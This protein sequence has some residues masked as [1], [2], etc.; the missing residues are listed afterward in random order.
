M[1]WIDSIKEINKARTNNRLVIF[2]GSGVSNNS[3]VPTWKGLIETIAKKIN[4]NEKCSGCDSIETSCPKEDCSK[5][6]DF[7]ATEFLRIP[8]YYYQSASTDEYFQTISNT[9][10]CDKESN[11]VDEMILDIAPHHIIT[12]N[13]DTLLENTTSINTA[14]YK[15]IYEDKDLLSN[16]SDGYIIKMHGDIDHPKTI[17]LK[18]SD[19]IDYEQTHPLISTYIKSLLVN[20]T[21]LFVGYSLNDNNLNLIIGWINYFCKQYDVSERPYSFLI[22]NA[23]PSDF[24]LS[25]LEKNNIFVIGLDTLPSDLQSK[26]NVPESL[27]HPSGRNLYTYLECITNNTISSQY[28]ELKDILNER[29]EVLKPYCKIAHEDLL[30][31]YSFGTHQILNTVLILYD[32]P[33]YYKLTALLTEDNPLILNT[34]QRAG[35]TSVQ[36]DSDETYSYDI[37]CVNRPSLVQLYLD[38]DYTSIENQI[39]YLS[40]AEKIYYYNLLGMAFNKDELIH[41]DLKSI[42]KNDYI[43]VLLHKTRARL[44]SLTLTDRQAA[45]TAE[46]EALLNSVPYA[47]KKSISFLNKM[48]SSFAKDE[49]KMRDILKKQKERYEYNSNTF[50]SADAYYNIW[51]L[52]GYAYNYYDFFINNLLPI[53]YFSDPRTYFASYIEAILCSY[54][55]TSSNPYN[56]LAMHTDIKSYPLNEI[57]VD[58]F[59]KYTK[60]SNLKEWINNYKI[61]VLELNSVDLAKIFTNYCK[62]IKKYRTY[63]WEDRTLNFITLVT[64]VEIN[65]EEKLS[66]LD[67]FITMIQELVDTPTSISSIFDGVKSIVNK[68]FS[69]FTTENAEALL[70]CLFDPN[71]YKTATERCGHALLRVIKKLS[72]LVSEDFRSSIE[73]DIDSLQ[74][75]KEK[76]RKIYQM[77][78]LINI[79]KYRTFLTENL[80]S[81]TYTQLFDLVIEK[82]IDFNDRVYTQFKDIIIRKAEERRNRPGYRTVPD[83]LISAIELCLFLKLFDYP[84]DLS[85]LKEQTEFSDH[86]DFMLNPD[87]FD[88][89]K[90]NLDHYMWQNLVYTDEYQS[91][92]IKHKDEILTADLEKVFSSNKADKNC[93]KIVYGILLDKDKLRSY[94]K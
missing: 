29:Y 92:F 66:I 89:S 75:S 1:N 26:A 94:G 18:E 79:E 22:Q 40:P 20:H 74:D 4:Y 87:D 44:I 15:V 6:F 67:S 90:V 30:S 47:Y 5:R 25:R 31:A 48:F 55:L 77:R 41:L 37:P 68:Y 17:V 19:Y 81:A 10:K 73:T 65:E 38:N 91:Y 64:L 70:N 63:N 57:D 9:L 45:R 42:S 58:I 62:G 35:I 11:A 14:K 59:V 3:G 86:L 53:N 49:N 60:H 84:I 21:F 50:Y 82:T 51:D 88:Y 2:V 39:P 43:S 83:H 7:N 61:K 78:K 85:E 8:E 27:T 32:K 46:L 28:M 16:A 13:Y 71:V 72:T 76:Y 56:E 24:E 33:M 52:Q 23:L 54:S 12:T 69:L 80:E 36:I 93:Q 34:F